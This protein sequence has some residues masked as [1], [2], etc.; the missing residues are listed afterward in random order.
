[1]QWDPSLWR[2]VFL[3]VSWLCSW[4]CS[5]QSHPCKDTERSS[6]RDQLIHMVE[7]TLFKFLCWC[8]TCA[9]MNEFSYLACSSCSDYPESLPLLFSLCMETTFLPNGFRIFCQLQHRIKTSIFL[10]LFYIFLLCFL[11]PFSLPFFTGKW[12]EKRV[13]WVENSR[14]EHKGKK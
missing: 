8:H 12:K 3:Q 11:F 14:E 13:R 9:A 6:K 2:C 1:M 5:H 7:E 4:H 10:Y